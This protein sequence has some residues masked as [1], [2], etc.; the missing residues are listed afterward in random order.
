MDR[1]PVNSHRRET[2]VKIF[3][4]A[5]LA[6]CTAATA[7]GAATAAA[8]SAARDKQAIVYDVSLSLSPEPTINV[9]VNLEK[10]AKSTRLTLY[11]RARQLGA[12]DLTFDVSCGGTPLHANGEN[13][14]LVPPACP[15]LSW[16]SRLQPVTG[17]GLLV[18]QQS[19]FNAQEKWG[20]LSGPSSLPR[21]SPAA[22]AHLTIRGSEGSLV[23]RGPLPPE[24]RPPFFWPLG[25]WATGSA[26]LKAFDISYHMDN[27]AFLGG[28]EPWPEHLTGLA[29]FDDILQ[30]GVPPLPLH[31][32]WIARNA[33]NTGI[34]GAAGDRVVLINYPAKEGNLTERDRTRALY[35]LLH[36]QFHQLDPSENSPT[37]ISES[38]ASYY[39]LKAL[40][41]QKNPGQKPGQKVNSSSFDEIWSEFIDVDRP[42]VHS[43]SEIEHQLKAGDRSNYFQ[44]Y[45]QGATFW[46]ALDRLIAGATDG[47]KTLDDYIGTFLSSH[48]ENPAAALIEA[49]PASI[50]PDVDRLLEK[51]VH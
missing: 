6:L 44:L 23:Y 14:Y 9:Q 39:A 48:S 25:S 21:L 45:L 31:V 17:G 41:R 11:S 4:K 13:N 10:L 1:Y 49:L 46:F 29:Y 19:F 8:T 38:L 34:S 35:V 2:K 50:R 7:A 16:K 3:L 40:R 22:P 28:A 42:V 15:S 32:V 43:F 33:E 36:E 26:T 20:L 12:P 51:Y 18:T 27:A 30:L 47:S 24:T 37:W 5:L